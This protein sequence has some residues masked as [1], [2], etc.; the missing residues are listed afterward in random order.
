MKVPALVGECKCDTTVVKFI[1]HDDK[2]RFTE[3][4]G[5]Y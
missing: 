3:K 4:Y 2:D 5:K 1:K